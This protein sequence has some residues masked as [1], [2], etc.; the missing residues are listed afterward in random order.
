MEAREKQIARPKSW[1]TFEDLC[2]ELFKAIW[3]DPLAQKNGRR[4]QPQHGV[5]VFGS[6]NGLSTAYFG[7]QCKGKDQGLGSRAT[8]RELEGEL[9]KADKFEPPLAHWTFVTTAPA[10]VALQEA[11]RKLSVERTQ[12]G[13]FPVTVL[14][15][16]HLEALLIEHRGVLER[17]YPE[18]AFDLAGLMTE[19]RR[20]ASE[21]TAAELQRSIVDS[22]M[23]AEQ[24]AQTATS[25][26][27]VC[28][29]EG[30]DLGPALMGCPL[31]PA[32]V[33]AC[34][35]LPEARMVAAQLEQAFSVRL[36]GEPGVGKSVCAGRT[37]Y[38]IDDA[39]LPAGSKDPR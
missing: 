16:G 8:V 3:G 5:D 21:R 30:R 22:A 6:K 33:S 1:E 38:V 35:F 28:F 20:S 4:G 12:K 26:R 15:W 23:R 13:L 14:G 17:F 27:P 39:H 32:D 19:L 10:D 9:I 36:E 7:V 37:L 29:E 24:N 31:G 11:A 34:P 18:V 2:L 25:W